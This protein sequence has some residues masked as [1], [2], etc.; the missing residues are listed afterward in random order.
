MELTGGRRTM[1][2][3]AKN[4]L[5]DLAAEGITFLPL[6]P[7]SVAVVLAVSLYISSR[8][9]GHLPPGP[10]RWPLIGNAFDMPR[11]KEWLAFTEGGKTY[12]R[13]AHISFN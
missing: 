13:E 6:L 11:E 7:T 10:R 4:I 9:Q 3:C 5:E 2:M 1:L 12:G 8:K